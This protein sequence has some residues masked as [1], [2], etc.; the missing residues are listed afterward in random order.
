MSGNPGAVRFDQRDAIATIT[1]DRPGA[2]NAMTWSMYEAF[3]A[4]LDQVAAQ[5]GL[6]VVVLRGTG[7]NFVAGT[8]I[9]QFQEFASGDDGVA[10]ERRLEGM[11][12][13]LECLPV[14]SLAAVEGYAAGGGLALAA[15]CDLRVASPNAQFGVP[16]ARTLG[17]CL[18]MGNYARL[19][20]SLGVARTKAML[21]TAEFLSADEARSTGFVLKVL[22]P[23]AFDREL[24]ML[25][26]RLA[27]L[28]PLT[29]QV[30]REAVRR[31]VSRSVADGDDLI[32]R[33][34]DSDDFR[35]GVAAFVEKRKPRWEGR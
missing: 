10:Y 21:L 32:H 20:A 28:A 15:A 27:S 24:E 18:S 23:H 11:L 29:L 26:T 3:D 19:V 5:P 2:R 25:C 12:A 31:I 8:D 17:N 1:F 34:Y 7:G 14:V 33:V 13:K 16:I 6:R 4:A 35:E 9:S 30:T 22:E